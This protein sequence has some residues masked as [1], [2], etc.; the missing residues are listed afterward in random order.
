MHPGKREQRRWRSLPGLA[1][2]HTANVPLLA[3]VV[4]PE[5]EDAQVRAGTDAVS[6]GLVVVYARSRAAGGTLV[7]GEP[8]LR[9]CPFAIG[10]RKGP[11]ELTGNGQLR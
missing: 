9:P 6:A 2:Q 3:R 1:Y 11:A 8:Q 5:G 10:R 4:I 7:S